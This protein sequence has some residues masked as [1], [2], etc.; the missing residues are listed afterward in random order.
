MPLDSD[1]LFCKIVAGETPGTII[2]SDELTVSFMDINPVTRGHAL[3]VP[4]N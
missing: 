3:A 1:G 4:R 2:D